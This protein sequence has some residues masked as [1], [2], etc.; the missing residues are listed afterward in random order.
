MGY[1]CRPYL[2]QAQ[3]RRQAERE[4][5]KL[6]KKGHPTSPVVIEGRAIARTF[7]GK[8][9]CNNLER[10]S[11][12]AN[13][14][15]RGRAY[16]RAGSVLD[17][18]VAPGEVKALVSGSQI[19]RVAVKVSAVPKARWTS[20]CTDCAGAIDSLV[21]LLQGRFSNRVMERICQRNTGLFPAPHD[22]RF[23]CSC[24]DWA[25]MCK[26]V[27]AVLYGVGARLDKGPEL[28]FQLRQVHEQD[29]IA[30]A[31]SCI[32]LSKGG[33][34]AEKVLGSEGLSELFG[35]EIATGKRAFA[36]KR[37]PAAAKTPGGHGA[38][39]RRTTPTDHVATDH[40]DQRSGQASAA[41]AKASSVRRPGRKTDK[42]S[43]RSS[44][45]AR[46]VKRSRRRW[47]PGEAKLEALIAEAIV[48]AYG[49]SEQRTGF[50]TK[51]EESLVLPLETEVLGVRATVERIDLTAADEIVAL[52]RRG[53]KRQRIPILDLPL[54]KPPPAGAE[55]I[56]AYR[57]WARGV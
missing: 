53:A 15:P 22:I 37:S 54:P 57:R 42:R 19:Y 45:E 44:E 40:A 29:L 21:E 17:L 31:G 25:S 46:R 26:H 34:P 32:P 38:R 30:K 9:W 28:L 18:Q 8:A 10:Y 41:A 47:P 55:W 39:P 52:C 56:E 5:Q 24:P 11:D 12:L 36:P 27:A 49:E 14:L 51:I 2:P 48:D 50:Y 4:L 7:W 3:R 16:V 23:S 13:R 35:L 6:R 33:L 43:G 20:I 1:E